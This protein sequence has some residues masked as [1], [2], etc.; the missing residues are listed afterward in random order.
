MSPFQNSTRSAIFNCFLVLIVG[1]AVASGASAIFSATTTTVSSPPDTPPVI[2]AFVKSANELHPTVI[3]AGL[4]AYISI[5]ITDDNG[6]ASAN[7]TTPDMRY[8]S[9]NNTLYQCNYGAKICSEPVYVIVPDKAQ[10]YNITINATDT[11]GQAVILEVPFIAVGCSTDSEC[12]GTY[13]PSSGATFCGQTDEPI[14][15]KRLKYQVISVCSAG[16][17]SEKTEPGVLEDC[18]AAGK[19]CGFSKANGG[20]FQCVIAPSINCATGASITTSCQCGQSSYEWY[21]YCCMDSQQKPYHNVDQCPVPMPPPPSPAPAT[22]LPL[23]PIYQTSTT[24]TSSESTSTPL[25]NTT[26]T[27]NTTVPQVLT[28]TPLPPTPVSATIT[29]PIQLPPPLPDAVNTT[30]IKNVPTASTTK[31]ENIIALC[32]QGGGIWCVADTAKNTGYCAPVKTGCANGLI[33]PT[34]SEQKKPSFATEKQKSVIPADEA[35][36]LRK[37]KQ[38]NKSFTQYINKIDT[39]I[40]RTKKAGMIIPDDMAETLTTAKDMA[41]QIKIAKKY[42][43][44][45]DIAEIL[46][47]IGLALNDILPRV[48]DLARLPEILKLV[49]TKI[50]EAERAIK[51]TEITAKRLQM[52]ASELTADMRAQLEKIKIALANIQSE[53]GADEYMFATLDTEILERM[54]SIFES[55]EH[56][57]TISAIRVAVNR[58]TSDAR[59]Y[60]TAIRRREK[61]KEDMADA[62]D[63]LNQ[64][65]DE[66]NSLRVVAGKRISSDIGDAIISHLRTIEDARDELDIILGTSAPD[67]LEKRIRKLFVAT[68]EKIN[69]F[70]IK[71]MEISE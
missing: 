63:L 70:D 46:P 64:F 54:D 61:K 45:Q 10:N 26:P 12:G 27:S 29:T 42:A 60:E 1:T 22:L 34:T 2:T 48:E 50:T 39:K 25:T 6:I 44:I 51:Q 20:Q 11:A 68:D 24:S 28:T 17:C 41:R 47:E 66:L 16:T 53:N 21:G 71:R 30:T 57:R 59:N 3:Y 35:K 38:A 67:A 62:R 19:I 36:A 69:P 31:S 13:F 65:K 49:R 37:L 43:D 23:I 9:T 55:A 40:A 15:T 52:D 18:G 4:R 32:L 33:S 8:N 14:Y 58:M 5:T 7:F 56:V